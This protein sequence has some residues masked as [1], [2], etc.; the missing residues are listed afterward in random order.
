MTLSAASM[1][2][3]GVL[4]EWLQLY[5]IYWYVIFWIINGFAQSTG[6]PAVVAIM[7]NWFG[8]AGYIYTKSVEFCYGSFLIVVDSLYFI[9]AV[10]FLAFGPLVLVLETFS[11]L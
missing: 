9:D 8:K 4:S 5:S 11:A 1:F 7:G 6:W 2:F 3:F 10:S